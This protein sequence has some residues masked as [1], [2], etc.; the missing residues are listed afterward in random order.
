MT[1]GNVMAVFNSRKF[2]ITKYEK[3]IREVNTA[4]LQR[5]LLTL[6][7]QEVRPSPVEREGIP[8][9]E[10][11]GDTTWGGGRGY[12]MGRREGIP[13]GAEGGIPHGEEG[14]DTTWGGGRGYHMGRRE[15]IPHGEE[16]G[17]T[18]WGGGRRYHMV[19]LCGYPSSSHSAP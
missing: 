9:G 13:H 6:E 12:H 19:K 8:H 5:D 7:E 17:D 16:G 2:S 1:V 10:E 14:G 15:G 4:S 18:T 11:G 3:S